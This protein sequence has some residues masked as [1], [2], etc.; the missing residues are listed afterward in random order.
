MHAHHKVAV[1]FSVALLSLASLG[2][3]NAAKSKLT[4]LYKFNVSHGDG[5]QGNLLRDA[6]GNLYGTLYGGDSKYGHGS[7]YMLNT[8]NVMTYI[9]YGCSA[10]KG[11]CNDGGNPFGS[12]I[13]DS[14]GN[15]YGTAREGGANGDG[16]VFELSPPAQG[17][18]T[19]TQKVLYS[20]AG[21][22]DGVEPNGGLVLDAQGNLWGTTQTGGAN[23]GGTIFGIA[24]GGTESYLYSFPVGSNPMAGLTADSAGNL[25]GTDYAGGANQSGEVFELATDGSETSLYSFCSVANCQDGSSPMAPVT[26]DSDGNVYG[27]TYNGGKHVCGSGCGTVFEISAGGETVLH[28]FSG[29]TDEYPETGVTFDGSGNIYGTTP[30]T[31]NVSYGEVF[32]LAPNGSETVLWKFCSLSGCKDGAYSLAGV[33]IDNLGNLYG[34]TTGGGSHGHGTIYTL[35][36]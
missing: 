24:P 15:L 36:E 11:A 29:G 5:P 25:Y 33:I 21:L 30:T 31:A 27:T 12:L 9:W 8:S 32:Q 28:E 2:N 10:K 20:F 16:V 17:S 14:Q 26:L 1:A 4:V 19:W 23:N 18:T 22:P 35:P 6:Q 3:V 7:V 34:T 13:T